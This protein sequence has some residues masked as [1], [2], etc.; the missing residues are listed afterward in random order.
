MNAELGARRTAAAAVVADF[1]R[2]ATGD[3]AAGDWQ[4]WALRLAAAVDSLLSAPAGGPGTSPVTTLR[5]R[6]VC[7]FCGRDVRRSQLEPCCDDSEH[8]GRL[9]C[10]DV[11]GCVDSVVAQ[12]HGG[13]RLLDADSTRTV[14]DV[15]TEMAERCEQ[16]ASLSCAACDADPAGLCDEHAAILDDASAYRALAQRIGVDQCR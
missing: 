13:G 7:A 5:L 12:L 2:W 14:V 3:L 1:R 15:L 10:A 9:V 8:A 16:D 4:S 11:R 6:L